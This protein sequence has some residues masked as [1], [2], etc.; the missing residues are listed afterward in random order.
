ERLAQHEPGVL[1]EVMRIDGQVAGSVQHQV[2]A[3]IPRD[4]LQHVVQKSESGRDVD[5]SAAGELDGGGELRL[6]ALPRD[7][8]LLLTQAAPRLRGRVRQALPSPRA[9]RLLRAESPG[10]LGSGSRRWCA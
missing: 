9:G 3:R 7:P 4:L 6:L 2:E 10:R 8:G 5:P 1:D